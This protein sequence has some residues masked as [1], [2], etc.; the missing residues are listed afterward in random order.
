MKPIAIGMNLPDRSLEKSPIERAI[1]AV[2]MSVASN[3]E[4]ATLS[5]GPRL[6]ITFNLSHQGDVP[7]FQGMRM[8]GF[9]DADNTLYFEA[10]VP[11]AINHAKNA[12]DYVAAIIEDVIDN[13]SDYFREINIAF[14]KTHWQ[15]AMPSMR[16]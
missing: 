6:D 1:T 11:E 7:S 3:A 10:C 13:A 9:N 4:I 16:L 2:A 5:G 12:K 15:A 8:G 14:D